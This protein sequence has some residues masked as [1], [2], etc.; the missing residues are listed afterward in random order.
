MHACTFFSKIIL[1]GDVKV[2]EQY[3]RRCNV[4]DDA[5]MPNKKG[6]TAV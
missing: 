2:D 3:I 5:C 4:Y 1:H 6:T